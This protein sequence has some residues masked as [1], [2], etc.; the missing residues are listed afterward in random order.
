MRLVIDPHSAVAPFEQVRLGVIRLID[1]G[2]LRPEDRLPTVRDL[3][4]QLGLANNTVAK[5]YRELEMSGVTVT[6]GRNGTFVAAPGHEARSEA[7]DYTRDYVVGMSALG[8]GSAEMLA[9][10]KHELE[11]R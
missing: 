5:A 9:L 10:L 2:A 7:I 4:A 8:V 6:R 11:R 3:A 1:T